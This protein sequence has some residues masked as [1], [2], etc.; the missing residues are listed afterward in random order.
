MELLLHEC[1][2]FFCVMEKKVALIILDGWGIAENPEVSAI[3][4]ANTP[5]YDY[6]KQHFSMSKLHASENFVGLPE[7]QMGNSEVGHMNIGAGRVVYQNLVKITKSLE[8][9]TFELLPEFVKL[10]DYCKS[11]EKPLHLMGLVSDGGVHS[12]LNHLIGILEVLKKVELS[13]VFI[14]AFTDGRD[15]APKSAI[16][17]ITTL[18]EAISRI[19]IGK[20]ASVSGRYYAMD[21]D[22][23]WGRIRK[24]YDTI[25][26]GTGK[27][28]K[29]A[30]V[31]ILA[32]YAEEVSDEFIKPFVIG[33]ENDEPIG[34]LNEDDAVLFFNFRTDRGRQLTRVLTQED[35]KEYNL[36]TIPLYFATMTEYDEDFKDIHVL[37][38]NDNIPNGLGEILSKNDKKQLRIAETEKYAHVTF[39]FNGGVEEP[40]KGEERILINSPKVRTYDLQPEMSALELTDA[41]LA[42]IE[43]NKHD[44]IC[45]NFANPDMV[46]H[47]GIMEAAIKACETVDYCCEK[48][49]KSALENAYSVLITA[50]HGNCDKMV[51]PDGTPHTAH[52]LSEVPFFLVNS[53]KR[54]KLKEG[55]LGDIAPT[56]LDLME[57]EQPKEM[58]GKS[59]IQK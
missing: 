50:D 20:I 24:A 35:I 52:T 57:I 53:H 19:G 41:V 15:T 32:S 9:N 17:F 3:D 22:Q 5:F 36:C 1:S 2:L 42:E 49:V 40:Y 56:I 10:I 47:T 33:D 44:F 34:V 39:F 43:K 58:T 16:E 23:R 37:F 30:K 51:N 28:F 25:T 13:N 4:K 29:S 6:A 54:F 46:G 7:Q 48:V 31:G 59:L 14:H 8:E 12:S 11:N 55:K 27:L 38:E 21:R 26:K 45:L 18:E